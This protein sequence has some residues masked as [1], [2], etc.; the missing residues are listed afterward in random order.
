MPAISIV[1][2]P[3]YLMLGCYAGVSI[4]SCMAL[5]LTDIPI[6]AK[7][8][9]VSIC[10]L[11]LIYIVMRDALLLLPW[12]WHKLE[13]NSQG[14]LRLVNR[15]MQVF[16]LSLAESTFIHPY[17][18]V[19]NFKGLSGWKRQHSVVLTRWQ[20]HDLQQFRQ[21]RTWLKWWPHT[22]DSKAHDTFVA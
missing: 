8:L 21:L 2:K 15:R 11:L 14:E 5:L 16:T 20:V 22:S 6:I 10:I 12:S 17:L 1:L 9:L 19:L 3:S 18:T 13:V 7:M 4:L